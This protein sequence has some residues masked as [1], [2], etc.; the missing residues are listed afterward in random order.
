M[1]TIKISQGHTL[2]AAEAKKRLETLSE[3]LGTEYGINAKWKNDTL[4]EVSRSGLSGSIKIEPK[5]VLVDLDLSF[6]MSPLKGKIEE[7]VKAKL[8]EVLKA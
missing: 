5:Q 2:D 7:R 4:A 8:A 3:Q 6:V 1:P